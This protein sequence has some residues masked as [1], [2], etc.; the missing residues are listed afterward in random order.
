LPQPRLMMP[1]QVRAEMEGQPWF[2][3]IDRPP[4]VRVHHVGRRGK[5]LPEDA[6]H[7]VV[8]ADEPYHTAPPPGRSR[9][10]L[11]RKGAARRDPQ[12]CVRRGQRLHWCFASEAAVAPRQFVL[13]FEHRVLS[14]EDRGRC[15]IRSAQRLGASIVAERRYHPMSPG[16]PQRNE[17]PLDAVP[18]AQP[19]QLPRVP[20]MRRTSRKAEIVGLL[21][22]LRDPQRPPE[23]PEPGGRILPCRSPGVLP[24]TLWWSRPGYA[25]GGIGHPRAGDTCPRTRS[26][27]HCSGTRHRGVG[28]PP[29]GFV[30]ARAAKRQVVLSQNAIDRPHPRQRLERQIRRRKARAPQ[31]WARLYGSNWTRW[32]ISSIPTALRPGGLCGR[33]EASRYQSAVVR[34][35]CPSLVPPVARAALRQAA[36]RE[37]FTLRRPPGRWLRR[38]H[39]GGLVHAFRLPWWKGSAFCTSPP[40]R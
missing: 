25:A 22:V 26:G 13:R 12:S 10:R 2:P 1:E 15:Q 17:D 23:C 29:H 11:P 35:P 31:H 39:P 8:A 19:S 38:F 18:Q 6:L 16:V 21:L 37:R 20:G 34:G 27:A 40:L 32:T 4:D 9:Q 28:R 30:A 14:G 33:R 3:D 7:H 24:H 36:D 5:P